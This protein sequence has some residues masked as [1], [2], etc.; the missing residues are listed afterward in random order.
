MMSFT[1]RE[2]VNKYEKKLRQ[3]N[4]IM[5]FAEFNS[6]YGTILPENEEVQQKFFSS[7]AKAKKSEGLPVTRR[8]YS[9]YNNLTKNGAKMK[10]TLPPTAQI[11][12]QMRVPVEVSSLSQSNIRLEERLASVSLGDPVQ[13]YKRLLAAQND[14]KLIGQ[15]GLLVHFVDSSGTPLYSNTCLLNKA[16][17]E[18]LYTK[19]GTITMRNKTS[20][21]LTELDIDESD[22][23][24]FMSKRKMKERGPYFM[25]IKN[26]KI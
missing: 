18:S 21:H 17:A 23:N 22:Y 11:K 7:L 10:T 19:K 26:S 1:L 4:E 8:L 25:K 14:R 24:D 15:N 13:K 5:T 3:K 2:S 9:I 20:I 6:E 16:N 12:P